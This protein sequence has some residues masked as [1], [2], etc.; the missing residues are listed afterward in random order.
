MFIKCFAVIDV[1]KSSQPISRG[2]LA[3]DLAKQLVEPKF[4]DWSLVCEGEE[5]PCHRFM[6]GSRSPVFR[7]MFEQ[8]GCLESKTCQTQIKVH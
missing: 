2:C 1:L 4:T 8:D 5:I 7:A 3:V 6:L